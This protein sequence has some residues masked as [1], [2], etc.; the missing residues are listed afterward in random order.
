MMPEVTARSPRDRLEVVT[1]R[2]ASGDVEVA[3]GSA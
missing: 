3:L 2:S 1:L